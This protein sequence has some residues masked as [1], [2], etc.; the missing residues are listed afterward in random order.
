MGY[1]RVGGGGVARVPARACGGGGQGGFAMVR[2]TSS[3]TL[4]LVLSQLAVGGDHDHGGAAS[5]GSE[6]VEDVVRDSCGP[7]YGRS[8]PHHQRRVV[9]Q[10]AGGH[11]CCWPPEEMRAFCSW[12]AMRTVEPFGRDSRR[13]RGFHTLAKSWRDDIIGT[14]R[15]GS[16]GNWKTMPRCARAIWSGGVRHWVI[17]TPPTRFAR[18]GVTAV[19]YQD[20]GLALP[21]AR[22]AMKSFLNSD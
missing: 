15:V 9:R 16:V 4:G 19:S 6:K 8:S 1:P 3:N 7:G 17:G 18:S 5:A 13:S 11:A 12:S 14:V 10:G 2:R 20:R 21:R 22:R